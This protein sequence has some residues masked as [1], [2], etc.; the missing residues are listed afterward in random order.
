MEFQPLVRKYS[1]AL[2]CAALTV[3]AYFLG[4][5]FPIIGGPVFG[6]LIG[7]VLAYWK[8]PEYL[9]EGIKF[10]SKKML[11][12]S[13]ILLGFGMDLFQVVHVG[14]QSLLIMVFTLATAFLVAH[15]VGKLLDLHGNVPT[16]VGVG[17]A[18]CGGSAIAAAAPVVRA[19]DK[20]M[21]FSISTIFLFNVIAVFI[22]PALGHLMG[23]TDLEFGMWAG[24]A[25]NDTSSVVAAGYSFSGAA[26][27]YA[28]IVKLTRTLMIIPVTLAL[29]Y[30]VSKKSQ[31]EGDS[32]YSIKKIFPWF[33]IGFLLMSIV[34]TS[35]VLPKDW[36]SFLSEAGK[37]LII[38]AMVAIGLSTRLDELIAN[39]VRPIAL[40]M[41][42][43]ISIA[44]VALVCIY[45]IGF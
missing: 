10:T 32:T 7:M 22:F 8:R 23:M 39:G 29:A 40:G 13:I 24:T 44:V 42:C 6:I 20:E 43:W 41:C 28:T 33:V 45:T 4:K 30:I 34:A 38:M 27:D 3:P 15:Y 17:T 2:L 26:G 21:A 31:K 37:V 9:N 16:L 14:G 18:I 1:G 25:I 5:E 11:Q 36:C 19:T 12:F 35:G